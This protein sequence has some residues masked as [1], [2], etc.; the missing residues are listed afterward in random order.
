MDN[1][2]HS[3]I[4]LVAGAAAAA[5]TEAIRAR[6]ATGLPEST[7]RKAFIAVGMIG[8]NLPDS[9]LLVSYSDGKL[10]YLLQHRG[11]THTIVGAVLLAIALYLA[12]LAVLRAR[13]HLPDAGDRISLAIMTVLALALH[14]CM[15][16]L[17]NY[18]LHPFWPFDTHWHY[19]DAVFIVEPWYW[20][21]AAPLLL[22]LRALWGRVAL[23][24]VLAGACVATAVLYRGRLFES[25]GLVAVIIALV[26]FG[27][28]RPLAQ[29]SAVSV[30]LTALVTATFVFAAST[31]SGRVE[32]TARAFEGEMLIDHV[33]TPA[34]TTPL[35]W[36]VLLL[37]K[38]ASE[39]IARRGRIVLA[40][41]SEDFRCPHVF[42]DGA[43]TAP[44]QELTPST[45]RVRWLREL[46]IPLDR[47][48]GL[49]DGDCQVAALMQFVRAPFLADRDGV[50]IV[51]DLRFDREAEAGFA[52]L[53]IGAAGAE[54]RCPAPAPWSP[55]R[56]ELLR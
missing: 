20:V 26:A 43:G 5:V 36:D 33:L 45:G 18:G 16:F 1:L 51:G 31:A 54:D 56:A 47:F 50:H 32:A 49:T 39:Y 41:A 55:P 38:S 21:A 15:D 8:G 24:L 37:Q 27:R 2:T 10:G 13:R 42:G 46:R 3:V 25:A 4:G 53:E 29:T 34:P 28:R 48:R 19:G 7:R 40:P 12:T 11:Y 44:W 52:E 23:G 17:N 9:D 6:S 35:C 22:T 30:A 14:L